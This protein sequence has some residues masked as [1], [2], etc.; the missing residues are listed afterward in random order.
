MEN[1]PKNVTIRKKRCCGGLPNCKKYVGNYKDVEGVGCCQQC[2]KYIDDNP[3]DPYWEQM[4]DAF[5]SSKE[6]KELEESNLLENYE[7]Y[8][9]A[10]EKYQETYEPWPV[11]RRRMGKKWSI[12]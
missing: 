10:F 3:Y 4:E 5:S 1:P 8:E 9:K 11:M 2:D 6:Y 7:A 12:G